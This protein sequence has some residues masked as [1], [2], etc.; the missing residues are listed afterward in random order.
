MTLQTRVSEL[1]DYSGELTQALEKLQIEQARGAINRDE[2]MDFL[3]DLRRTMQVRDVLP[4]R[5]RSTNTL[6]ASIV[7]TG[8][9]YFFPTRFSHAFEVRLGLLVLAG[10]CL[11]VSGWS[12]IRLLKARRRAE[13]WLGKLEAVVAK[14]GTIFDPAP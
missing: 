11:V 6:L 1:D 5:Q 9:A 4:L 7:F 3:G 13:A 2:Q 12:F 8:A 10:L 14:G